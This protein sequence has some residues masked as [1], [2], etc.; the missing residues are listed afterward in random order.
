MKDSVGVPGTKKSFWPHPCFHL[1]SFHKQSVTQC[2][3]APVEF[4]PLF[5]KCPALPSS[6]LHDGFSAAHHHPPVF[7]ARQEHKIEHMLVS[8]HGAAEWP[9]G[10]PFPHALAIKRFRK[11][12]HRL[13]SWDWTRNSYKL[14]WVAWNASLNSPTNPR[15]GAKIQISKSGHLCLVKS[16]RN[17]LWSPCSFFL[18]DTMPWSFSPIA[19]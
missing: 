6:F 9:L 11:N 15:P 18:I 10:K 1:P 14:I 2:M 19:F 12:L 5:W 4:D 17:I 8:P 7:S 16:I 13:L 3:T